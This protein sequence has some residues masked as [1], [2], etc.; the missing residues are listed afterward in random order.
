MKKKAVMQ[1]LKKMGFNTEQIDENMFV[2]HFE[3]NPF[4]YLHDEKD[5]HLLRIAIPNIFDINEENEL[6]VYRAM[7]EVELIVKYLKM[8]LN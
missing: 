3:E 2:F 5:E 8:F 1:T 7:N 6:M 4:L